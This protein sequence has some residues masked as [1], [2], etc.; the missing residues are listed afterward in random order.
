ME[1]GAAERS[2]VWAIIPCWNGR[3]RRSGWELVA[4][5]RDVADLLGERAVAALLGHGLEDSLGEEAIR[6]GGDTVFLADAAELEGLELDSCLAVLE[7]AFRQHNPEIVLF[8]AGDWGQEL[9]A[10]LAE[11]LGAAVLPGC[12]RLGLDRSERLLLGTQ[13]VFGGLEVTRSVAVGRPQ[14]ATVEPGAVEPFP[15]DEYRQ[16]QVLA[17]TVSLSPP[18]ARALQI[19]EREAPQEPHHFRSEVV[20]GLGLEGPEGFESLT[21]LAVLLE[22]RALASR[23]AVGREWATEETRFGTVR[24]DTVPELLLSCGMWGTAEELLVAAR[25]PFLVA[26]HPDPRAPIFRIARVA[27]VAQ[28]QPVIRALIASLEDGQ[29]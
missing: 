9:A 18:G 2:N 16:G 28:V 22:G 20:G 29:A 10:R 7:E 19:S 1:D 21:R 6:R 17:L 27:V 14:M 15:A 23:A 3:I 24:R 8:T 4:A 13:T 11:R 5:A 25:T 26:I 12:H